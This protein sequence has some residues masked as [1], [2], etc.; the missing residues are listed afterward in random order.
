MGGA[1]RDLI[2][3]R[4]ESAYDSAVA[5]PAPGAAATIGRE[6]MVSELVARFEEQRVG[7]HRVA[8]AP[9]LL[10]A[11]ANR[12]FLH[13]PAL[14]LVAEDPL[15]VELGLLPGLLERLHGVTVALAGPEH[16]LAACD[17]GITGATALISSL[18]AV[19]VTAD[20]RSGLGCSLTPRRHFVVAEEEAVVAD[21]EGWLASSRFDP[22]RAQVLI[23]GPSRTADI[24]KRLVL[25]VHGPSSMSVFMLPPGW[26][27]DPNWRRTS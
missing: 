26:R 20:S 17:L 13:Q 7:Y 24:E 10:D 3:S 1:E 22:V 27:K 23:G 6:A 19:V 11:L 4:L 14:A 8:G 2:L 18:G 16:D 9:E 12:I 21:L 15:L 25:G 5:V